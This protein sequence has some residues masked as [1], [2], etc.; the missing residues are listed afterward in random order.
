RNLDLEWVAA[1]PGKRESRRIIGDYVLREQDVMESRRFD[2]ALGFGGWSI[3]RH[4]PQGFLDFDEPPSVHIHPPGIY[5]I[6]LRVLYAR[7]IPN[8]FLAGRDISASHVA[9][10]S[11]RVQLTCTS[12]GQAVGTALAKCRERGVPPREL[13]ESRSCVQEVQRQLQR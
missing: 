12:V 1:M 2:D 9:S 6:P 10:C 8:L 13:A 11:A 4:P 7:D 5:Q 3:D